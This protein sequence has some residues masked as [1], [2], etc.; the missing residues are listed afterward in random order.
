MPTCHSL[1]ESC[2][3]WGKH[4]PQHHH[5]LAFEHL[6]CTDLTWGTWNWCLSLRFPFLGGRQLC[7]NS[8]MCALDGWQGHA[9]WSLTCCL[10]SIHIAK[11]PLAIKLRSA[12]FL[13]LVSGNFPVTW[14]DDD[15]R[16][17]ILA[18]RP[19]SSAR[20]ITPTKIYGAHVRLLG[21]IPIYYIPSCNQ[22]WQLII[23]HNN[24]I[25]I[26]FPFKPHV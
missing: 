6:P 1:Q 23:H 24:Y 17:S 21:N 12:F 9:H 3:W 11:P 5:S 20:F 16:M 8:S 25:Y 4:V 7:C 2:C 22:R 10:V 15:T 18:V 13:L 26:I 19:V 14:N